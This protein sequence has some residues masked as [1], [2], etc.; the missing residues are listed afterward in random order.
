VLEADSVR[1][2]PVEP[3]P[4]VST[5]GRI[6]SYAGPS[7]F[8]VSGQRVAADAG[9]VYVGGTAASLANGVTV[10]VTGT[11]A[12]GVLLATRIEVQ[13]PP[14]ESPSQAEV[15]GYI[16]DFVSAANFKV[17]GQKVDAT[18]ATYEHGTAATLAN[19]IKVHCTGTI[20]AGVLHAAL[21]QID[22]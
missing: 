7:S 6:E 8:V 2:Y 15:E 5:S 12:G 4:T 18:G 17:N 9:T 10:T 3:A 20:T 16:T 19:G 13:A 14:P 11:V 1:I 22:D 21:V